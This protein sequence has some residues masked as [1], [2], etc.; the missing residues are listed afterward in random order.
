L[1]TAEKLRAA[2]V[3][4]GPMPALAVDPCGPVP[5]EPAGLESLT[6]ATLTVHLGSPRCRYRRSSVCCESP[7]ASGIGL[8]EVNTFTNVASGIFVSG[9]EAPN[10]VA[11]AVQVAS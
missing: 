1:I 8:A 6:I 2:V 9:P 5:V 3:L 11:I 4:W 10:R 7:N